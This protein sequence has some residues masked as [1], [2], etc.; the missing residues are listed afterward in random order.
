VARFGVVNSERARESQ[1][2][3]FELARQRLA[4][5]VAQAF[6]QVARQRLSLEVAESSL[7]RSL[8]LAEASEK[9]MAVGLAS[10]LDV[11][12][13]ELQ[14]EQAR[15]AALSAQTALDSTLEQFRALLGL[16]PSARVEPE[17]VRLPEDPALSLASLDVLVSAAYANRLELKEAED[18]IGDARRALS[19]ARNALLPQLDL[20]VAVTRLSVGDRFPAFPGGDRRVELFLSTSYPVERSADRA[21]AAIARL[22]VARAERDRRERELSLEAEVRGA[23]RDLERTH[24]SIQV[25][26]KRITVAQEQQRLATLRYQRGVASNFDVVDA[27]ASI[28]AARTALAG[29]LADFQVA[30]YRLLRTTGELDVDETFR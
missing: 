9:R 13:A 26:R 21:Q 16:S 22:D 15:D 25:Q 18:R 11:L 27:E 7:Q 28:V 5:D 2:R 29:L 20:N 10:R 24:A 14:A 23:F 12:R 17:P 3:S 30:R 1:E 19:V 8:D 6:Y 4:V